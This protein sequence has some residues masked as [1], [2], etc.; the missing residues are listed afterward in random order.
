V[1]SSGEAAGEN[2]TNYGDSKSL[3]APLLVV[4]V[5]IMLSY[6]IGGIQ[7]VDHA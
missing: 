2:E 5:V 6:P 3:V 7:V 1:V 4:E